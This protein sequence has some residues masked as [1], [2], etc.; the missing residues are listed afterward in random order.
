V[1]TTNLRSAGGAAFGPSRLSCVIGQGELSSVLL[2]VLLDP[3]HHEPTGAIGFDA[4]AIPGRDRGGSG[5][6][7]GYRNL[8]VRGHLRPANRRI[9]KT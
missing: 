9:Y 5:N 4:K 7:S 3:D 8:V 1:L 6:R 2:H